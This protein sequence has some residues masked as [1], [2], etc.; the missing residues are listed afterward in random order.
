[1][2]HILVTLLFVAIMLAAVGGYAVPPE[3]EGQF[4]NP[5]EPA[6][7]V[8][9]WPWLGLRKLVVRTHDGLERGI[10][11]HPPAALCEGTKGA[12][13]GSGVLVDHSARGMV[14]SPLPPRE[15]LRERVTYEE[16]AMAFIE[17]TMRKREEVPDDRE[18]VD[19]V[20]APEPE[21][22]PLEVRETDVEKAQR[23]YIPLRAGYRDRVRSGEGNLLRLAR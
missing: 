3:R 22:L 4:G 14:Y 21:Y 1:M 9:K 10:H 19:D 8:V 13:H 23:R 17:E 2:K 12:V 15:P 18:I 20:D 16:R 7:R 6:L 11:R 5:E